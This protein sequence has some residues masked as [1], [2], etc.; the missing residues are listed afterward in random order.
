MPTLR[1]IAHLLVACFVH[2]E[3]FSPD[4]CW[5][6]GYTYNFCCLSDRSK[7]CWHGEYNHTSCCAQ[8]IFDTEIAVENRTIFLTEALAPKIDFP[9]INCELYEEWKEFRALTWAAL[10]AELI[11]VEA[12]VTIWGPRLLGEACMENA[13]SCGGYVAQCRVGNSVVAMNILL[14][15]LNQVKRASGSDP[16]HCIAW[17][18]YF[19]SIWN[20]IDYNILMATRWPVLETFERL[21]FTVHGLRA[22]RGHISEECDTDRPIDW[23]TLRD[24]TSNIEFSGYNET[25]ELKWN[26]GLNLIDWLAADEGWNIPV[27]LRRMLRQSARHEMELGITLTDRIILGVDG[28]TKIGQLDRAKL[29]ERIYSDGGGRNHDAF[30]CRQA[31]R[32]YPLF[33]VAGDCLCLRSASD[34]RYAMQ[35]SELLDSLDDEG[36]IEIH[37]PITRGK[38]GQGPIREVMPDFHAQEGPSLFAQLLPIVSKIP[39]YRTVLG[40][41]VWGQEM[42]RHIPAFASRARELRADNDVIVYALDGVASKACE[43][44]GLHFVTG[45]ARSSLQKY[46]LVLALLQLDRVVM[47][48]D[49]D[50]YWY[51]HPAFA[52]P[53]N[54][55]DGVEILSAVDFNSEDCLM[56][57]MFAIRPS[58]RTRHWLLALSR[59]VYARPYVHCQVAWIM[60]LGIVAPVGRDVIPPAPAWATLD[61]DVFVNALL[62]DGLGWSGNYDRLAIFH[63]FY[64]WN[65]G[66]GL[67]MTA[68]YTLP[69]YRNLLLEQNASDI[70]DLVYRG[71]DVILHEVLEL[72]IAERPKEL[73]RCRESMS[74]TDLNLGI[75]PVTHVATVR[76]AQ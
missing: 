40:T 36:E 18:D 26:D 20:G 37:E 11:G 55:G 62:F 45:E 27:W 30:T 65:S 48:I 14:S 49:F 53:Q 60:F 57:A 25:S 28:S 2:G 47:W 22:E 6:Y 38:V 32:A 3:E 39:P 19:V 70:F 61:P 15:C 58:P 33:G 5:A 50:A 51:R 16:M 68:I 13:A 42:S 34:S 56:N 41:M 73:K 76:L 66:A 29:S 71:D 12:M 64:G 54:W 74:S 9:D 75:K 31:C 59:W 1:S 69:T 7:A 63:F 44:S 67:E 72:S 24:F 23:I 17:F 4:R 43:E 52:L 35:K 10:G 8:P 21:F 46:L